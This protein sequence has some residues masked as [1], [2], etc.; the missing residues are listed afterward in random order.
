M[1]HIIC[2]CLVLC[3]T[4]CIFLFIPTSCQ[5]KDADIYEDVIGSQSMPGT[6]S[7]SLVGGYD[8]SK[9]S[10]TKELQGQLTVKSYWDTGIGDCAVDFMELYPN[11]IID[12][13]QPSNDSLETFDDYHNQI[14]VELMSG[15]APD[16]IDLTGF[17]VHKYAKSG[18]LCNLYDFMDSDADFNK[19]DYYTN[20][21]KAKE[22][23]GG[24]YS[25]PCGFSYDMVYASKPLLQKANIS[26]PTQLNYKMMFDIYDRVVSKSDTTPKLLPGLD[27]Y[28][29]FYYEF[30][31]YYDI[32][33]QKAWF[34]SKRFVEYLESTQYTIPIN[35]ENDLTR[36]VETDDFM[37]NDYLFCKLDISRGAN[38]YNFLV[39]FKNI[40]DPVPMLSVNGK[41]CFTTMRDYAIPESCK[42]KELAW[43][44][45]KYYISEKDVPDVT[46]KEAAH[47]YIT[48]Y[49]NFVPINIANY[50]KSFRF[51]CE[52]YSSYMGISN[53]KPGDRETIIEQ[54]L[55]RINSWN[56]Q[57]NSEEAEAEIYGAICEDLDNF[58]VQR[59]TTAKETASIIQNKMT[60]FLVE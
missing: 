10:D 15:K 44:F 2:K 7:S 1:K 5:S 25:M 57:R 26:C 56:M 38:I 46:N 52:Y 19:D 59:I 60:A 29:F 58:Y 30:P 9:S 53:W 42:N 32:Q 45:V 55:D 28:T 21:F 18:L 16:V 48:V 33:T 8:S 17:A 41:A 37:K 43:E 47:H 40:T 49:N 24:L 31:D 11:V 23:N 6:S 54:A 35:T 34:N 27:Q 13:I 22:Y 14:V 3:Y 50:Y 12:V 20:I 39:D 4:C 36:V 51:E